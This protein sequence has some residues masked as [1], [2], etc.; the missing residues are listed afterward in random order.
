MGIAH[1]AKSIKEKRSKEKEEVQQSK[2]KIFH[3]V[4]LI[5]PRLEF[6]KKRESCRN[7]RMVSLLA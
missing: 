1:Q 6:E 7:M 2:T 4:K 3:Q 5:R